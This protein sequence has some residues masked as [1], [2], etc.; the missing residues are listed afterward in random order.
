MNQQREML[1]YFNLN[2]LP[3][4]KEIP[5]EQL[6]LLPSLQRHLQAAQLL[7]HT[8]GIGLITGR[9]GT[10]KSCLLR[11]LA[12]QLP[13]GLYRSFYLCHSSVGIVEFYT[14]LA[15][16]LGLQPGFRRATMFREIKDHVLAL[17]EASHVHPVLLIDEAH[18]LNNA[19][20]AE[21]R[22]L[23]NFHI[24]SLS[25]LTVILC[26]SESLRRKFGLSILEALASCITITV[27]LDSLPPEE[28]ASFV[29]TRLTACGANRPLF[30]KN[31]I[32]L[33]HQASGGVM[34][35]AGTIANAALLQA[36]LAHTQ[37]V[38][39]EHVQAVVQ[40]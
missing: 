6:Q 38:E 30:T 1:S 18:L 12:Q 33:V 31:A 24:D 23:S 14:H 27:S 37:Q 29:E 21:I 5:V 32:K 9:A 7:V 25:A 16:L 4:T 2:A 36:F 22:L 19:I 26:G 34:R 8:R 3:F 17:N 15:S 11:L 39:A 28:T 20:L 13:P 35:S 40:R 10:G